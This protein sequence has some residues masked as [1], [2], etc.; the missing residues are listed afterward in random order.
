MSGITKYIIK[1]LLVLQAVFFNLKAQS[2]ITTFAGTGVAGYSGDNISGLSAQLNGPDGIILDSIGNL[3]IADANNNRVRKINTSGIITTISGNG[4]AGYGGD[5]GPGILAELNIPVGL[6]MNKTGVLF[7]AD[8]INNRIRELNTSGIIISIAG[9]GTA[10]YT[11]DGGSGTLAELNNPTDIIIDDTGNVYIAD[12]LNSTIRKL[13]TLG[14]ITTIAGNGISGYIGDGGYA[15]AAELKYPCAIAIDK[16]GNLYVADAGNNCIRMINSLGIIT[17]IAGN[18]TSGYIGDGGNASSAKLNT[19]CG[20]TFDSA[21]NLYIADTW[22]N[23]VRKIDTN[24]IIITIVG[25]G[26]QGYNGDNITATTAQ[27]YKPAGLVFDGYGNL[28]IADYGNNRI[29]KVTN[30]TIS[31]NK[32]GIKNAGLRI[33]PNPNT[34]DFTVNLTG[35][36]KQLN[37]EI[38]NML[39]GLVLTKQFTQENANIFHVQGLEEGVYIVKIITVGVLVKTERVIVVK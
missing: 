39:G 30:V 23:V 33:Y 5:G 28:Y 4:T 3:Y 17:T 11:G 13:N 38:Y 16:K 26:T 27:L 35:N 10:G 2:I 36:F 12:G 9:N 6:A 20:I 22:N 7:I 31:I 25:S 24:G 15:T 32:L 37:L 1:T 29:R 14:V 21:G 19:P 34:G 8:E 18:G